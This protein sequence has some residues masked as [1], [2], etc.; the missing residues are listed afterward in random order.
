MSKLDQMNKRVKERSENSKG[1]GVNK[2]AHNELF[3][4]NSRTKNTS[5]YGSVSETEDVNLSEVANNIAKKNKKKKVEKFEDKH[6]KQ[7]YWIRHD[8]LKALNQI[9]TNRGDKTKIVNQALIEYFINHQ[10]DEE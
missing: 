5:V 9:A 3:E 6:S 1:K 4:E 10:D 8:V 7:T 2:K